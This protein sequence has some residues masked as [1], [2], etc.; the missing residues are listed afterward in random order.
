M[1]RKGTG[2]TGPGI[3]DGPQDTEGAPPEYVRLPVGGHGPEDFFC[4][5]PSHSNYGCDAPD[6]TG[7]NPPSDSTAPGQPIDEHAKDAQVIRL[8]PAQ[9][10]WPEGRITSEYDAVSSAALLQ[11]M[12]D[13]GQ[14]D[15]VA[16]VILPDGSFEGVG[17]YN[18]CRVAAENR[19]ESIL[20]IVR[21]GD[22]RDVVL[23]NLAT[24][25]NQSKANPLSEVE[26]IANAVNNEGISIELVMRTTGKT[27]EWVNDKL[28][29]SESCA[30]VRQMLGEGRIAIGHANI[31]AKLSEH[32]DQEETLTRQLS[33]GWTVKQLEA[34]I[35]GKDAPAPSSPSR[36]QGPKSLPDCDF[37]KQAIGQ[38][39]DLNTLAVCPTC[40]ETVGPG[41]SFGVLADGTVVSLALPV[42]LLR[43]IEQELAGTQSGAALAE[44]VA[45][46]LEAVNAN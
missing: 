25:I 41:K 19:I 32:A 40:I 45:V 12:Q 33:H 5:D 36:T 10:Y 21:T 39:A 8:N 46:L 37:C 14:Q 18:R 6:C 4:T 44:R 3:D 22:H 16:V 35:R 23:G 43:S 26:G 13:T 30:M 15:A 29:I 27:E 17:G 20:C 34:Y 24:S 38:P 42:E 9:I 7:P 31:L 2:P 1:P 28:L 11:S